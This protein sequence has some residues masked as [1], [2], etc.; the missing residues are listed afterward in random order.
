MAYSYG[1]LNTVAIEQFSLIFENEYQH[2]KRKLNNV[3][4][5]IHGVVG[6][7]YVAKFAAPFDLSDRG[8]YHSNI[9]RTPVEYRKQLI[10][11]KDKTALVASDIFEQ[12]LVNASEL[13]NMARQAVMSL[14]RQQ[15]QIVLDGMVASTP[16]H[17]VTAASN[18]N[19][20]ALQEAKRKLDDVDV[21]IEDRYIVATYSQ[22]ESLLKENETTSVDYNTQRTLVLGQIETFYGFKFIWI[23]DGMSTGGL[24]IATSVRKCYAWQQDAIMTPYGIE[25][26][27]DK[28]WLPES[29]SNI[30]V[31]KVRMG[32][33]VVRNGGIVL[34]NCT[35][36]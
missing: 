15:D 23:S 33:E 26:K 21:P 2:D 1:Q 9:P 34:I 25:P 19:L 35:E 18:L 29:Q 30:I 32:S 16:D 14:V 5:E 3:T 36:A 17:T 8:A 4:Q 11:M 12:A 6:K 27:V 31:P 7:D 22:Q 13:Q 20:V 24:P 10:E 28:D